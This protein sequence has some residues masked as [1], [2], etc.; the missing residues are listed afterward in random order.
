MYFV[1]MRNIGRD[2]SNVWSYSLSQDHVMHGV[3]SRIDNERYTTSSSMAG[4]ATIE[5]D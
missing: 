3:R 4:R 2:A 5:S 1:L